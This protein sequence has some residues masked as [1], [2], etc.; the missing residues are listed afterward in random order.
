MSCS[1]RWLALSIGNSRLHWAQFD[2]NNLQK[3]W[4]TPHLSAAAVQELIATQ[5]IKRDITDP[6]HCD[7]DTP[8]ALWI[9]SVV[10]QQGQLWQE[11]AAVHFMTLEQVP[12][13]GLYPTLGIDRALAILGAIAI[14][15]SPVLVIDAG[16]ALTFTGADGKQLI[17]GAIL[18]GLGLQFQSLQQST[19]A[20]PNALPTALPASEERVAPPLLPPRWAL[21]TAD[22]IASGIIYTLLAGLQAF[23]NDWWQQFPA[24]PVLLTGGD[25]DRLYAYLTATM[26][27]MASKL[28]VEPHLIFWGMRSVR[29]ARLKDKAK[30]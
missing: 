28:T 14:V 24:S 22:A 2:G 23:V 11:Y 7:S 27:A 20:L 4:D 5:F 3:T 17:G 15:G 26:P 30:G 25:C 13:A 8:I 19:A 10:P 9:A 1:D 29:Q 12:L 16:T 18:P 6:P 21:N